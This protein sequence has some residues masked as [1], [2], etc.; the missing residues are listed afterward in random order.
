M[1]HPELLCEIKVE[2]CSENIYIFTNQK[3]NSGIASAIESF[4]WRMDAETVGLL[5][6]AAT[7]SA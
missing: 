5:P 2:R 1:F 3:R 6:L 4:F 7:S